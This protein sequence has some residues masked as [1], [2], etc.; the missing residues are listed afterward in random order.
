MKLP[1]IKSRPTGGQIKRAG[2]KHTDEQVEQIIRAWEQTG[3]TTWR[4]E[5]DFIRWMNGRIKKKESE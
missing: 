2:R 4:D 3:Q 1:T 5:K